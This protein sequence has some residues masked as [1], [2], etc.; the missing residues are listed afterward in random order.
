MYEHKDNNWKFPIPTKWLFNSPY[1]AGS[2]RLPNGNTFICEGGTG[3]LFEVTKSGEIV[4][5]FVNPDRKAIFRAYRYGA[6]FPGIQ[7][8]DLSGKN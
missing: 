6:D 3:R 8:R 4:W 2:Q 1:I 7:G 5:E